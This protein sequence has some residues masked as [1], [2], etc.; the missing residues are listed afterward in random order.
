[1][2]IM[3]ISFYLLH[4]LEE[5]WMGKTS[6]PSLKRNTT[7]KKLHGVLSNPTTD[8]ITFAIQIITRVFT[9]TKSWVNF[10]NILLSYKLSK[11]IHQNYNN[12]H[13]KYHNYLESQLDP[14]SIEHGPQNSHLAPI[15]KKTSNL[16]SLS[17]A[18]LR[19]QFLTLI[20]NVLH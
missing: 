3:S 11:Q 14:V 9:L 10:D 19:H 2:N 5:T 4:R 7:L 16:G 15:I 13:R 20:T 1:M 6:K 18:I 12:N 17:H 8:H